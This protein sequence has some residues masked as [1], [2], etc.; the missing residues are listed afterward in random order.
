[1]Y[2]WKLLEVVSHMVEGGP[3][4]YLSEGIRCCYLQHSELNINEKK[5]CFL[6]YRTR[7]KTG[8]ALL[9]K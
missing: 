8:W 4:G 9:E 7:S 6:N 2:H 5:N 3:F 1:M